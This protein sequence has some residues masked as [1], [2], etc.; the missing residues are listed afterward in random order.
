MAILTV[1]GTQIAS[2]SGSDVTL[3]NVALGSSVVFPAGH[4]LQVE[5]YTSQASHVTSSSHDAWQTT[6]ILKAVTPKTTTSRFLVELSAMGSSGGDTW[7]RTGMKATGSS[8]STTA[9]GT[10]DATPLSRSS[11]SAENVIVRVAWSII[12]DVDQSNIDDLITFTVW[13]NTGTGGTAGYLGSRSGAGATEGWT[14]L[15]VTEIA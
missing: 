1:G 4:V 6:S 12:V 13:M 3:D 7:L 14:F 15:T 10:L 11:P 9:F 5:Q 8:I 2:S